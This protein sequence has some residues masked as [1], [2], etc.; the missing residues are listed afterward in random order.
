MLLVHLGDVVELRATFEKPPSSVKMW[1][2]PSGG[3]P[4]AVEGID[5]LEDGR[6]WVGSYKPTTPGLWY[7]RVVGTGVNEG[8]SQSSFKVASSNMA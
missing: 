2:R 6:V 5:Q 8:A 4:I 1:V 7:C 3:E